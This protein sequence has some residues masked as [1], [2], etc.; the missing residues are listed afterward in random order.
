MPLM[1]KSMYRNLE[2]ELES[3]DMAFAKGEELPGYDE[4]AD[5]LKKMLDNSGRHRNMDTGELQLVPYS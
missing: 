1:T 2:A 3:I 4:R 5:D